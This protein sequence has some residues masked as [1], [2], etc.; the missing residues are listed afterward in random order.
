M[1]RN[2]KERKTV[3]D[4]PHTSRTRIVRSTENIERKRESI[5]DQPQISTRRR[6]RQLDIS[7]RLITVYFDK[8]L[9]SLSLQA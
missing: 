1:I 6:F 3:A 9:T 7:R 8:K 4:V 5:E 2:F